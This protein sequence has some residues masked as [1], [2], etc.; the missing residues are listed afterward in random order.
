MSLFLAADI[1]SSAFACAHTGCRNS[2]EVRSSY[3]S[4][5]DSSRLSALIIMWLLHICL[6][7]MKKEGQACYLIIAVPAHSFMA[8]DVAQ[9]P[10]S[11]LVCDSFWVV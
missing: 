11:S 1:K 3:F 4:V 7:L 2:L 8:A 9:T 5:L 10:P 6:C